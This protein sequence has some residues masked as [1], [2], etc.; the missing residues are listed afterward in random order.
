MKGAAQASRIVVSSINRATQFSTAR[1]IG[2][3]G[4]ACAAGSIRRRSRPRR[5]TP[6]LGRGR[7]H[8]RHRYRRHHRRHLRR[9]RPLLLCPTDRSPASVRSCAAWRCACRTG[10]PRSGSTGTQWPGLQGS[11]GHGDREYSSDA[12]QFRSRRIFGPRALP[13]LH[14]PRNSTCQCARPVGTVKADGTSKKW[15][16][17]STKA[18]YSSANRTS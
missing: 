1:S 9:R 11:K 18:A 3:T 5:S 8:S 6:L 4:R 17:R 2:A 7:P 13:A 16:P 10:P 12:R 14:V 15:A